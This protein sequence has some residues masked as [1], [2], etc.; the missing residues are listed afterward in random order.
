MR[1]RPTPRY[2]GYIFDLD[3]TLVDTLG[4]FDAAARW[5]TE[6]IAAVSDDEN[7]QAR[8]SHYLQTIERREPLTIVVKQN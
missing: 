3:G 4:D 6:A 7:L 2:E 5:M 1:E 8:L